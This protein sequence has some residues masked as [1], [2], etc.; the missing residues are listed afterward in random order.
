MV[1]AEVKDQTAIAARYLEHGLG[2]VGAL[3]N[4][5]NIHRFANARSA[6]IDLIVAWERKDRMRRTLVIN[7]ACVCSAAS[8]C[9]AHAT[10]DRLRVERSHP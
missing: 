6:A 2:F 4:T 5:M 3:N 1:T 7:G 10:V 8:K 9:V